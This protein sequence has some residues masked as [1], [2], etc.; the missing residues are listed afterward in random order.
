M[1]ES[2]E[3]GGRAP[4]KF[5]RR[6]F[7]G[8]S[9]AALAGLAWWRFGRGESTAVEAAPTG[10]P[11][12]VMIVEFTD[13]GERTGVVSVPTIQ[14]T[15]AEWKKELSPDSFEVARH[16]GT[17]RPFTGA[18]LNVHEKGVFRCIGCDTALF[19][20]D[21]KFESGTGWP[22][23]WAP[24]AKENVIESADNSFGMIRTEVSCRRCEAHTGHVF[25]D[26][27]KPTGLRYCMNSVALRFAKAS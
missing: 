16:A 15:E 26:G 6:V 25:D 18:L 24:I 19:N 3:K 17:E 23:F 5:G 11:K 13:A 8:T 12:Q 10:A 22:S 7:L 27:P 4:R 21:T 2:D 14:K 9:G 1:F 20:A